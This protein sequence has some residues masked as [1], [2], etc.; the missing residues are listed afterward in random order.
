LKSLFGYGNEAL[1]LEEKLC[2]R[3]LENTLKNLT[4]NLPKRP[5]Y[6]AI[7]KLAVTGQSDI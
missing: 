5:F 6:K 3:A 4:Q 2:K 7:R 1:K